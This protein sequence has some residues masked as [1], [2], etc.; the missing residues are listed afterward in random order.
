MANA[1]G[2][3]VTSSPLSSLPH[4][5][6]VTLASNC[7]RESFGPVVQTVADCLNSRG[8]SS[9][10]HQLMSSI[11]S[12]CRRVWNEERE[13]LVTKG[14][15]KLHRA[16]GPASHGYVVEASSIRAALLVLIQHD[17]VEAIQDQKTTTYKL[18]GS[19]ARWLPRYPRFVEYAKKALDETAASLI[20]KLLIHG[21]MR[22]VDAVVHTVNQSQDLDARY[23]QRQAVVEAFRRLVEGGFIE[24]VPPLK[25]EDAESNEMEWGGAPETPKVKE[26]P[27]M[28]TSQVV[29]DEDPAVVAL[30]A[31]APYKTLLPRDAIWRVNLNMFHHSIRSFCLGRLVA[32]RFGQK[33]TS[34]GSMVTAAL[35]LAAHKEH[36]TNE[37]N[38]EERTSFTPQDI[39][40]YLPKPVQQ[41]LE[42]KPGG[43][44]NNLSKSLVELAHLTYPR[45]VEEIE[46]ATGHANGGKFSIA[47]RQLVEHLQERIVHQVIYD[48]Q[49]EV[50]A[51]ICSILRIQG[52]LESDAI[53]EAAMVPAK[54]TREFLHRLYRHNYISLLSLATSKQH[55]YASMIHLWSVSN[56]RILKTVRDDV[57]RAMANIRLRRQHEVDVGKEW[58]E[59]AKEAGLTD[60]NENE[61]DKNNYNKFCQG[62]ER[63][64]NAILQLD[65]TLMVLL[66]F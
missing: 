51:R 24:K 48:S 36:A 11:R 52:H 21:R 63:L 17:L 18:I 19:R 35:K 47:T 50:A 8:S 9:T 1:F 13:R 62:L 61:M 34:C 31:N 54:D 39:V 59:R 40:P 42:K 30:L 29:G 64:D 3:F 55:N 5:P 56:A 44:L 33:V 16:R 6:L 41:A 27:S 28:E 2:G 22:T 7:I 10:L 4:D 25:N 38:F 43:L 60:V 26:E 65:E 49:G 20:E 32:E 57:A 45:V 53:A 23:T 15:Y 12:K 66:D 58:I 46:E 37:D 14:K